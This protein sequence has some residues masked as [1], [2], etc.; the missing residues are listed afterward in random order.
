M[1]LN[2]GRHITTT[3]TSVGAVFSQ[4]Y[5]GVEVVFH[6]LSG[7]EVTNL[8]VPVASSFIQMVTTRN[9]PPLGPV[10]VA[11]MR[12][13]GPYSVTIVRTDPNGP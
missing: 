1:E 3:Q 5:A 9:R 12:W 2:E 4:S 6:D 8:V 7:N 10:G 11:R 13:F